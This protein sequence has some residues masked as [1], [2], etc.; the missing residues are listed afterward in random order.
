MLKKNI[1]LLLVVALCLTMF[2]YPSVQAES[3]TGEKREAQTAK[4]KL[5]SLGV[6]ENGEYDLA[7]AITRAEFVRLVAKTGKA[8]AIGEMPFTDVAK[9]NA[10]YEFILA[11]YSWG[12]IFGSDDGKFYPDQ[13]ISSTEALIIIVR[14][15]G[16]EMPARVRGGQIADYLYVAKQLGITKDMKILENDMLTVGEALILVSRALEAQPIKEISIGETIKYGK[17]ERTLMQIKFG[18]SIAKGLVEENEFTDL[19]ATDSSLNAGYVRINGKIYHNGQTNAA[20]FLG[21]YVEIY[22]EEDTDTILYIGEDEQKNTVIRLTALDV[23]NANRKEV[24]YLDDSGK[25]KTLRLSDTAKLIL[26]EKA[27]VLSEETLNNMDADCVEY[28]FIDNDND[29]KIDVIKKTS[30]RIYTISE[31]SKSRYQVTTREGEM[32]VLDSKDHAC[33]IRILKDDKEV[34]I[35]A[36][37]SETVILYAE[38]AN[39]GKVLKEVVIC[40]KTIVGTVTQIGDDEIYV[41]N[42]A[43][44]ASRR[45]LSELQVGETGTVILSPH[46]EA[47]AFQRELRPVLG[48]LYNIVKENL[49][50][51]RCKIFTEN[52]RWVTL[53]LKSK[54][55]YN[56]EG[57]VRAVDV[58]DALENK[59]QL[60]EYLVNRD[61]FI[62]SINTA[63]TGLRKFSPEEEAAVKAN[64]FRLSEEGILRYNANGKL[65]G[66][67]IALSGETVIFSVPQ[68]GEK[69]REEDYRIISYADFVD[70]Q[71]YTVKIYNADKVRIAGAC[72]VYGMPAVIK[73]GNQS[74][75]L[76]VQRQSK[77]FVND[78]VYPAIVCYVNGEE[79]TL[80]LKDADV[81][82]KSGLTDGL[83]KNDVIRVGYDEKGRIAV[84][85]RIYSAANGYQ[86]RF[87]NGSFTVKTAFIAGNVLACDT[88]AGKCLIQYGPA[89]RG[90]LTLNSGLRNVYIYDV[91]DQNSP[92]TVGSVD[93][94]LEGDYVL[95]SMYYSCAREIII[96]RNEGK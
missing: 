8:Y 77:V 61:G 72:V 24:M 57:G 87:L 31:V 13:V 41:D 11:A 94:I 92:M 55:T 66:Q 32:L 36:L 20:S 45:L 51:V 22:Y 88:G 38:S 3:D 74:T 54:I 43:Y 86:Q 26:N 59:P 67:D 48:Y 7:R 47:V 6:L 39:I 28:V 16:G 79:T 1:V 9:S 62:V 73:G 76:I 58:Q 83:Q 42:T 56:G 4:K 89:D 81:I 91:N 12:Y 96:I 19:Y 33:Q 23:Y 60:I 93:D 30:Y 5:E 35:T 40:T 44:P 10:N 25:E 14:L 34:D 70:G 52:N 69:G 2:H 49:G 53:T 15:M 71:N 90:V 80:L 64:I 68:E 85:S 17:D 21:I 27:A 50:T 29:G 95:A 18:I 37:T 82:E 75:M 46:G 84:I 65:L 78:E 63:I